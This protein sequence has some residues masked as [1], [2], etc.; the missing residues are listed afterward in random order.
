MDINL[1]RLRR[2]LILLC[3]SLSVFM[4]TLNSSI[5][6]ISLPTISKVF[7]VN[8]SSIQWV[9]T[10]YLLAISVLLPVWGKISDLYGRKNIFGLGFI[11]FTAGSGFCGIA[12]NLELLVLSRVIQAAGASALMALSF[13]IV[14]ATF[15][16]NERGKALGITGTTAA[17]G[18]LVGPSLGGIL[19]HAAG[20]QSIFFVEVP[21]GIIGI[22]MAY[23]VI[24]EIHEPPTVKSF[25]FKGSGI[26][27]A[28]VLL[29]FTGLLLI[30][31]GAIPAWLFILMFLA[32][33]IMLFVFIK[34]EQKISYPLL[35]LD[36]FKIHE[37]SSGVAAGYLSY[38]AM[39]ATVMFIP[40]YLQ[41]ALKLNTLSAGLLISFYPLFSALIAPVSGWLSDKIGY[42]PLTIAGMS[43]LT[44]VL[45]G[46]S[47]LNESSPY[48]IVAILMAFLGVGVALFQSPNNSSVMG[49]VPKN[50]LGVAG[51]INALFRNLGLVSGT[52]ASV[53]IFSFVAGLN[54]NNINNSAANIGLFL[55]GYRAVMLFVALACFIGAIISLKRAP[56]NKSVD[57]VLDN[58]S[59]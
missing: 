34:L 26:F 20:W 2:W 42:R 23:L 52:T 49:A 15:P 1:T 59:K 32:S 4:S 7:N 3:V 44:L 8:I 35:N 14:T 40:F 50:Q 45:I 5:V 53:M 19:V 56:G 10:S 24:P 27:V 22:I 43:V 47:L 16:A 11:V 17:I 46:L 28:F 31:D 36:L 21:V 25:D 39:S 30:Q 13:G 9:V 55:K 38:I 51:G 58:A 48:F 6:N 12:S 18:N 33:M 29:L 37:F 41:L 54:I 57:G